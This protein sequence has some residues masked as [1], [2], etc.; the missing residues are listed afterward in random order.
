MQS[1]IYAMRELTFFSELFCILLVTEL[2]G[3]K[4]KIFS[5]KLNSRKTLTGTKNDN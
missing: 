2:L 5:K 1:H 4:N 3:L